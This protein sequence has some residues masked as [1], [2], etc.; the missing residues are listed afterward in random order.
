ML[1]IPAVS[2]S[3]VD[4]DTFDLSLT[5]GGRTVGAR[6]FLDERGLPRDF[7][8]E[9]RYA[10]MPDGLVRARWTTPL[11]EVTVVDGC[12]RTLRGTAVWHLAEGPFEYARMSLCAGVEYNVRGGVV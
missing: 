1:L 3:E 8:S 12:T 9:E 11:R 4:D 2:W 10:D 7:S 6:V 5:D